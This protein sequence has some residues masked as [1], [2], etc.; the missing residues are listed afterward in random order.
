MELCVNVLTPKS[1]AFYQRHLTVADMAK[2]LRVSTDTARR[3]FNNK[4]GVIV[5]QKRRRGKRTYKTLR[6]PESVA[7]Q[8]YQELLMIGNGNDRHER[9]A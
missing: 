3:I 1:A 8:V 9:T 4:P 2:I 5:I 6:I 7:L